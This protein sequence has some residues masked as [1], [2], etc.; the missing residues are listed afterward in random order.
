M[1]DIIAALFTKH[2]GRRPERLELLPASGSARRYYRIVSGGDTFIG[3]YYRN[4]EENRLFIDFSRHF[5][6]KGLRVPEIY[7]VAEDGLT[8]IQ[9]DLGNQMLLDLME[10]E[11]QGEQLGEHLMTL[12]KKALV[13][14]LHFQTDGGEGLDYSSCIPRPAFDRRCILWDLNYFKYCF[15]RLA[16]SEFSEE[17]LEDDFEQLTGELCRVPAV[18][19]MFRDFQSR[20]IMV[21][22]E[23]VWFIDY[24]G[25]R[26][27]ALQYDV[28]SL[29][30]D[31]IAGI[32]DSQREELL[33]YYIRQLQRVIPVDT[34]A[35]R[36]DYYRFVLIR[37]LQAMGAFGL[38]G[39]FEGKQH[40]IDS[41][42]PGIDS[43]CRLFESGRLGEG[44]PE[45]RRVMKALNTAFKEG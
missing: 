14:L 19:F 15:L 38:R 42:A 5:R 39:L 20:N 35:F 6:A 22:G 10:K 27:G 8:Y 1:E 13:E 7:A 3:A 9:E 16:G 44:Y 28:A 33:D 36:S 24:Q 25:G 45:I 31:A 26:Q 32:P 4:V 40:F 18:Y 23:E 2:F 11:R 12:Y 34:E 43:I 17:A 41:I 30:Y 37:L 29:L 21:R